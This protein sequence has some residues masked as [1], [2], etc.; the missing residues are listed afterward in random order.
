MF[1][2]TVRKL[3]LRV[4]IALASGL[5]GESLLDFGAESVENSKEQRGG[6]FISQPRRRSFL[7]G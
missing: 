7:V 2:S 5:C 6:R 3:E 1:P 4:Y